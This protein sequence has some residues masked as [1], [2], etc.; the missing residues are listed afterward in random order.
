VKLLL[1]TPSLNHGRYLERCVESVMSQRLAGAD[2]QYRILD[3]GSTDDSG[4]VL[5][6]LGRAF[7]EL[8]IRIEPDR[9][10]AD[11][12][13][14]GF[15]DTD[16]DILGWLNADD[17]LLPGSLDAVARAFEAPRVDV[18][19]GRAWFINERDRVIGAYPTAAFDRDYLT[20]FCFLSQPSVF[21]RRS[22]YER[23]GGVNRDL[24]Y[25]MDYDL[26][27]RLAGAGSTFE[28]VRAYLSATRLYPETKTAMGGQRFV[29][30]IFSVMRRELGHV[31]DA[32][33]LYQRFRQLESERQSPLRGVVFLNAFLTMPGPVAQKARLAGWILRVF[34]DHLRAKAAWAFRWAVRGRDWKLEIPRPESR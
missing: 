33:K 14:R 10:Q 1:V 19:Y 18:V 30:E 21:F 17:V 8:E 5:E 11:A 16:A 6:K 26:W 24:H 20:T 3:A 13:R 9:G 22:A 4:A 29:D 25:C 15:E 23:V 31:P 34:F 12:L 32:W 27:L 7:P 2:I 28:Y